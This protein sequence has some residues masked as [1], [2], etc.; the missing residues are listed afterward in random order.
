MTAAELRDLTTVELAEKLNDSRAELFNLRFQIAVNQTDNTAA[1]GLLRR[2]VARIKTIMREQELAAW[3]AQ[4]T[5][6]G[7]Q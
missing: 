7:E 2:D 6:Q 4:N 3:A 5:E 1:L